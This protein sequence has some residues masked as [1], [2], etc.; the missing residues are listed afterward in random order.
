MEPASRHN[1][2]A[3]LRAVESLGV[4]RQLTQRI[5]NLEAD[6][7][8]QSRPRLSRGL[9]ANGIYDEVLHGALAIKQFA[10]QINVVIHAVGILV[11][12]PFVLAENEVI[13]SLSVG[14]GNTGRSHDL[15]TNRQI[16]VQIY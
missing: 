15:E 11:S 9:A 1:V 16:A 7:R 4:G 8:E 5:A 2:E 12:L 6:L 14:A 3:A 13:E 10:G